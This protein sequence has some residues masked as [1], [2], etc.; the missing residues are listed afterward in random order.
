MFYNVRIA[1]D[2]KVAAEEINTLVSH[3]RFS[4]AVRFSLFLNI[5]TSQN[6][7]DHVGV[8]YRVESKL[9]HDQ[10][11]FDY[12]FVT[13]N[14]A[15]ASTCADYAEMGF[16][17]RHILALY[18][19]GY[20]DLYPLYQCVSCWF[21]PSKYQELQSLGTHF[22][23]SVLQSDYG[24]QSFTYH[25]S[26]SS[27][28]AAYDFTRSAYESTKSN[29]QVTNLEVTMSSLPVAT[30][31]QMS[32]KDRCQK[33]LRELNRLKTYNCPGI[34]DELEVLLERVKLEQK[35]SKSKTTIVTIN[36]V[37]ES[38]KGPQIYKSRK[39]GN[40]RQK[41]TDI[42][43]SNSPS[44]RSYFQIAYDFLSP[45]RRILSKSDD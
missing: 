41:V 4:S 22:I 8:L 24:V 30:I 31:K 12:Y 2:L 16:Y 20:I 35:E 32:N 26:L 28:S 37:S 40:K 13:E 10:N 43:S 42:V 17:N 34:V 6:T 29:K 21:D 9:Q 14:G 36:G 15:I 7:T 33:A 27:P 39:G 11:H 5:D 23:V 1:D 25:P 18:V 19:N 3:Y 45:T 38:I 44:K